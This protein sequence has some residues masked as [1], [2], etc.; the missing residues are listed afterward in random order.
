MAL[1]F[2]LL[3]ITKWDLKSSL[4]IFMDQSI[5][6]LMTSL[7][8]LMSPTSY[9]SS[10]IPKYIPN[11]SIEQ[12]IT[13]QQA[14]IDSHS[15]KNS[16]LSFEIS[17]EPFGFSNPFAATSDSFTIIPNKSFE[18]EYPL[19]EAQILPCV[20]YQPY[21]ITNLCPGIP[22]QFF[23]PPQSSQITSAANELIPKTSDNLIL[24]KTENRNKRRPWS[25]GGRKHK[26]KLSK[27]QK[28]ASV[29]SK[30]LKGANIVSGK[31][32][33][34]DI[35]LFVDCHRKDC[36]KYSNNQEVLK[37]EKK[38]T[39]TNRNR[40]Q[41]CLRRGHLTGSCLEN[42]TKSETSSLNSNKDGDVKDL[43]ESSINILSTKGMF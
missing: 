17:N 6:E 35:C 2:R 31:K 33:S 32:K 27:K 15:S 8:Q 42:V 29:T 4:K 21:G 37:T 36:P 5:Q 39:K 18:I 26:V 1:F 34:C 20:P 22:N 12:V 10:Q 3:E 25:R 16:N 19:P 41:V 24:I 9:T 11:K 14:P 13:L 43:D 30:K 23:I 38:I 7:N 28:T 40:C